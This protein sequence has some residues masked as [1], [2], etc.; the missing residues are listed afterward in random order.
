MLAGLDGGPK[1]ST[2]VCRQ[3][4]ISFSL[5]RSGCFHFGEKI[6]FEMRDAGMTE[7][8]GQIAYQRAHT[9][10]N[11]TP[12]TIAAQTVCLVI[13]FLGVGLRF[14]ERRLARATITTDDYL[15]IL[16]L[17]WSRVQPD[18]TSAYSIRT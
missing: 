16:A 15:I 2:S 1:L 18:K 3:C 9:G 14:T 8:P 12:E 6:C 5:S 7:D 10:D 13:A 17:V 11:R 4:S